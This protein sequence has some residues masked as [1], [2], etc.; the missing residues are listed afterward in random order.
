LCSVNGFRDATNPSL[1]T[2]QL[3]GILAALAGSQGSSQ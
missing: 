1:L 2:Q 3:N